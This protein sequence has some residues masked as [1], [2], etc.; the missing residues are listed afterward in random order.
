MATPAQDVE[1]GDFIEALQWNDLVGVAGTVG[2]GGTVVAGLGFSS[3][4]NS[5]GNY[6]VTFDE[7][8]DAAPLLFIGSVTGHVT[9]AV[10][11]PPDASGFTIE[12]TDGSG[13]LDTQWTFWAR[14][15]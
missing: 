1:T 7:D 2:S 9:H 4:K 15:A 12:F 6:T 10:S 13:V 3:V 8:F 14:L 11:P 5:T